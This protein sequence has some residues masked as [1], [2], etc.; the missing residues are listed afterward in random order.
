MAM[1]DGH[2]ATL[3]DGPPKQGIDDHTRLMTMA[4]MYNSLAWQ[5]PADTVDLG[6]Y[7]RQL[8]ADLADV[9][10]AEHPNVHQ[11]CSTIPMPVDLDTV[12]PGNGPLNW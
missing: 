2:A 8:C 1:L 10:G 3:D 6:A 5:R 12:T 4:R 11:S 7:I 9:H